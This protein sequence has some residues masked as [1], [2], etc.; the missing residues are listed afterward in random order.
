MT[1]KRVLGLAGIAGT[2]MAAL[3][4]GEIVLASSRTYLLEPSFLD[5]GSDEAPARGARNARFRIDRTVGTALSGA[6]VELRVLGDSTVAGVGTDAIDEALPVL[7]ARRVAERLGRPVHVVG[8]GV[9]GAR[10]ADLRRDQLPMATAADVIVIV[11]GSNDVIHITPVHRLEAETGALLRAARA[12]DVPVVLGGVPRFS[13][14]AAFAR[15]LRDLADGYARIQRSAQR[16]A[17]REVP[18]VA[19][20]DIAALASP[21]FVGRPDAMSSDAFHPATVGYGFWA[22][23]LAPAVVAA[24]ATAGAG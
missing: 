11:I 17:A 8:L 19:F 24:V 9:S 7:L 1:Y 22:D 2:A 6:P 3:L 14:V 12:R 10:T 23:A 13:G 21:R 20:V 16:R 15:P 5:R 4:V 18:G